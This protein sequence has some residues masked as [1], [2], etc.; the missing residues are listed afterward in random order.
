VKGKRT[1]I[2]LR[3]RYIAFR[4]R[5]ADCRLQVSLTRETA[6]RGLVTITGNALEEQFPK[7]RP[8]ALLLVLV[9]TYTIQSLG[10][11]I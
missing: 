3:L 9:V 5:E 6:H 4:T 2:T 10:S 8:Y 7:C 11:S 1:L